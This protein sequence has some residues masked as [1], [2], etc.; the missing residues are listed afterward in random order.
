M[1]R[2]LLA[3]LGA[4]LIVVGIGAGGVGGTLA[5]LTGPDAAISGDAGTVNGNGYALVFNEFT[6]NTAGGEEALK[7]IAEFRMGATSRNGNE[8]FLGIA[9]AEDVNNYLR[10]TAREI[11]SDLSD[12]TARVVPVPGNTVP[13]KPSEQTFWTAQSQGMSP[14]IS[15]ATSGANQTLV[16][17]NADA[18]QQVSVDVTIGIESATLF[19]IGLALVFVGVLFLVLG[20]WLVVVAFRP[21]SDQSPPAPPAPLYPPEIQS[22]NLAPATPAGPPAPPSTNVPPAAPP[23][24]G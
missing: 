8:L 9:P 24:Q 13:A 17:M 1:K 5:A 20:I 4:I 15:L 12:G 23:S 18:A 22:S 14:T 2:A 21:K 11:V 16:I 6:I 3:I 7:R 10:T 19:P